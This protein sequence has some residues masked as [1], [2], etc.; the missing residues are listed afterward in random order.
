MHAP[1]VSITDVLRRIKV[2]RSF[3]VND[4]VAVEFPGQEDSI[5]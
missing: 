5:L 2:K 4:R 3:I 1:G